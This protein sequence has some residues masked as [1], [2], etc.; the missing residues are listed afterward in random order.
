MNSKSFP[1]LSTCVSLLLALTVLTFNSGCLA[2]AAGAGATAVAWVKGEL[3]TTVNGSFEH[4]VAA[5]NQAVQ[6]LQFAKVSE[7]KD[8]LLAIIVARNA[9]D[10]KIEIKL[11]QVGGALTNVKIR[12]GI[13]G[14]EPL[15]LAVLEKIKA[16]L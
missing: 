3:H 9:A 12:V 5:A 1:R 6:Q 16:N 4:S 2:A 10:K 13:F 15:S 7:S 14:D 8:A 11:E